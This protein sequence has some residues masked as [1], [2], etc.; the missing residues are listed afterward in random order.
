MSN[1]LYFKDMGK[2]DENNNTQM[3]YR[4]EEC[5]MLLEIIDKNHPMGLPKYFSSIKQRDDFIKDKKEH[6]VR[7]SENEV[8]N[9]I[10]LWRNY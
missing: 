8:K 7:I 2:K 1:A 5:K 6:L 4:V 3:I 10:N 9:I